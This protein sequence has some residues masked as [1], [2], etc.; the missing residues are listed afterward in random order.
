MSKL[1]LRSVNILNSKSKQS[2]EYPLV[3]NY[4]GDC[5]ENELYAYDTY[6]CQGRDD[7]Y[8]IYV[9]DGIFNTEINGAVFQLKK[10]TVV[11]FPPKYKYR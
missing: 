3:I 5:F 4:V 11:L 1:R 2:D 8:L 10:G 7:Y 9:T 6:D